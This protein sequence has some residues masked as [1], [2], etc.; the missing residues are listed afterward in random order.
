MLGKTHF[1]CGLLAGAIVNDMVNKKIELLPIAVTGISALLPD[2]DNPN[3]MLGHKIKPVS[4]LLNK[5]FGHRTITHSLDFII[6]ISATLFAL[7]KSPFIPFMTLGLLTHWIL[8]ALTM[9][10][11]GICI[12]TPDVKFRLRIAKTGGL[13]DQLLFFVFACLFFYLIYLNN[14]I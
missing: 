12:F 5:L 14:Q 13:I 4:I 7:Y 11:V 9:Q 10:G 6:I 3:S 2:I 1:M 8:D